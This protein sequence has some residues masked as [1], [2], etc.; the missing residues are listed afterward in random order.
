M[1]ILNGGEGLDINYIFE[2]GNYGDPVQ[3]E[4]YRNSLKAVQ[5]ALQGVSAAAGAAA[6]ALASSIDTTTMTDAEIAETQAKIA[7][8]NST[9]QSAQAQILETQQ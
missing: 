7:S 2:Q 8:Y 1:K 5:G 9:A 4:K 6:G 3:K